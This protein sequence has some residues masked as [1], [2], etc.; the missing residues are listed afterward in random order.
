MGRIFFNGAQTICCLKLAIAFD[1]QVRIWYLTYPQWG[2]A[3]S[4]NTVSLMPIMPAE[5]SSEKLKVACDR[6][7]LI[8]DQDAHCRH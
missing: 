3:M 1:A 8:E 4:P 5:L 7:D 6:V 2:W